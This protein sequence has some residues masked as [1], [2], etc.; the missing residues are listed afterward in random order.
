MQYK[1]IFVCKNLILKS[2]IDTPLRVITHADSKKNVISSFYDV[3]Y[4][5][6]IILFCSHKNNK[7]I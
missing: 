3:K 4:L 6:G 2:E 1:C 7:L 5:E